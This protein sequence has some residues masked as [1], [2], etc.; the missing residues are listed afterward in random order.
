MCIL[1]SILWK[2]LRVCFNKPFNVTKSVN[3]LISVATIFKSS[4]LQYLNSY[5]Q[6]T[7]NEFSVNSV[8]YTLSAGNNSSY[9]SSVPVS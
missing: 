9:Y 3:R 4:H 2:V 8:I 5:S 1:F 7:G 6:I